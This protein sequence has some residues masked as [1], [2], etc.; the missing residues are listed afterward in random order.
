MFRSAVRLA[1]R[2]AAPALRRPVRFASASASAATTMSMTFAVPTLKDSAACA[3]A[4]QLAIV[5]LVF[6]QPYFPAFYYCD[7]SIYMF[8]KK[9]CSMFNVVEA[10]T[11]DT[12]SAYMYL[13]FGS[14]F[15]NTSLVAHDAHGRVVGFIAAYVPPSDPDALFVWQVRRA[16]RSKPLCSA[17][18]NCCRLLSLAP[19]PPGRC[20]R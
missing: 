12:N 3:C 11:L 20:A 15:R 8:A 7:N 5:I 14:H 19:P 1:S 9:N 4:P 17:L 10:G 2:R 6:F 18:L 13:L 16:L